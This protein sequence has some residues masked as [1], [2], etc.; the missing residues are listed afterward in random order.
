MSSQV[1]ARWLAI[2][3]KPKSTWIAFTI[4]GIQIA[5]AQA[6][7]PSSELLP[8]ASPVGQERPATPTPLDASPLIT[9]PKLSE[10]KTATTP[11]ALNSFLKQ[12]GFG[13]VNLKQAKFDGDPKRL[14]IDVEVNRVGASLEVDTGAGGTVIARGSLKR[15]RLVEHKTAI[16]V[17]AFGKRSPS[18]KF[19]SLARLDTLVVGN[20]VIHGV[21]VGIKEIPHLDGFLG[22]PE[23]YRFGA[24]LD[25]TERALYFA[26]RGPSSRTSGKLS[27]I[28]QN[29][30]FTEVP[31]RLNSDHH[32]EVD[33]SI[34]GVS[35]TMLVDTG[36]QF[37]FVNETV[38]TTAGIIT[39]QLMNPIKGSNSAR[40]SIGRVRRVGIGDFEIRNAD[41]CFV[42]LMKSDHPF[43]YLL[44]ISE[45]VS[46]SAIIDVGGLRMYLRHPE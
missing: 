13:T 22:S 10:G 29:N 43:T 42:D 3:L 14:V 2:T 44:G 32:L 1:E 6:L 39:K 46:N 28:L 17:P 24:V 4:C 31:L 30:G 41:I 12:E 16:P 23:M 25:C 18:N 34:D 15:L 20:S 38:A 19:W 27:E 40:R 7:R 11:T 5:A 45:L 35:S 36:S 8:S 9:I 21:P 33:C 37:T 26:R